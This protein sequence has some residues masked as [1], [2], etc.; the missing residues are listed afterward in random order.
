MVWEVT[1]ITLQ[2]DYL[3]G[4]KRGISYINLIANTFSLFTYVFI[5][6]YL[7][8]FV[9]LLWISYKTNANFLYLRQKCHKRFFLSKVTFNLKTFVVL[10]FEMLAFVIGYLADILHIQTGESV[11][12]LCS[13]P[14]SCCLQKYRPRDPV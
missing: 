14:A 7:Y 8:C 3:L 9:S 13:T 10:D 6:Y 12:S 5:S 2:S 11:A 1:V 4:G